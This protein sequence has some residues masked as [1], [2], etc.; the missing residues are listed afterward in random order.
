M[1]IVVFQTEPKAPT[2][3]VNSTSEEHIEFAWEIPCGRKGGNITEY[4][5]RYR[6]QSDT[7]F[8]KPNTTTNTFIRITSLT[9]CTLYLFQVRA[10]TS[11]GEGPWSNY[12]RQTTTKQG[13]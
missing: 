9:P 7:N 11:I 2:V 13:K 12:T 1:C 4:K 5:Y 3:S 6:E 10:L 8:G